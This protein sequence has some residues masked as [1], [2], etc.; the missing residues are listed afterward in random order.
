M[1]EQEMPIGHN[2]STCEKCGK[3]FICGDCID[4][5]CPSCINIKQMIADTKN[6]CGNCENGEST[7]TQWNYCNLLKTLIMLQDHKCLF[8]QKKIIV[9]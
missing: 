7:K 3:I 8:H 4:S 2:S 5:V 6:N 1:K 9:G